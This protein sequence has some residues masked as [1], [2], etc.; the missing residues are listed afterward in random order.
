MKKSEWSDKQLEEL[1]QNLPRV[2]DRQEQQEL[3]N[4]IAS[5][6]DK[7]PARFSRKPSWIL[8]SLATAAA[9]TLLLVLGSTFLNSPFG[10][11]QDMATENSTS[12]SI[13]DVGITGAKDKSESRIMDNADSFDEG[14]KSD[15][16]NMIMMTAPVANT[17]VVT[18]F[19]DRTLITIGIPDT[20]AQNVIPVSI[21]APLERG[22]SLE[23]LQQ[24][25]HNIREEDI[26]LSEAIIKGITFSEVELEDGNKKVVVTIPIENNLGIGTGSLTENVFLQ[27]IQETFRWLGYTEA[28][29]VTEKGTKVFFSHY[30]EVD[31]IPI[32]SITN[33]GYHLY[34]FDALQPMFL[35]PS[36]DPRESLEQALQD[37]K[38]EIPDYGLQPSIPADIIISNV[39]IEG[40]N[41]TI[42]FE[43][44]TTVLNG[45][46]YISMMHA[47]MLTAKEFGM[48]TVQFENANIEMIADYKLSTENGEPIKNQVPV[49]PN[50]L[51]IPVE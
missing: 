15:S 47:I 10:G 16:N 38:S 40:T 29:L 13:E 11:V 45:E 19:S 41:A 27:S 2:K 26:G 48:E 36:P 1:L 46:P 12:E 32:H 4:K 24:L 43:E 20:N 6:L 31:T 21:L 34:Q 18:D 44:G 22:N 37:M 7:E 51:S 14:S 9:V 42:F 39:A 5:R 17:N 33:K 8:P 49:S 50:L 3:Y 23:Q 30:G 35:V 28:E 25:L